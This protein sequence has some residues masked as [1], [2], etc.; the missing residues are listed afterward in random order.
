MGRSPHPHFPLHPRCWQ[1]R[2]NTFIAPVSH[3]HFVQH[4]VR[5][6]WGRCHGMLHCQGRLQGPLCPP[7]PTCQP[8]W[9]AGLSISFTSTR[10]T[11]CELIFNLIKIISLLTNKKRKQCSLWGL[12]KMA[13]LIC[14][15]RME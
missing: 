14:R 6:L 8:H 15:M 1:L 10:F 11:I 7:R 2:L 4:T 13:S 9:A 5:L 3:C 12:G